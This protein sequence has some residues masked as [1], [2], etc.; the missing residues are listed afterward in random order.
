MYY[1]D[2]LLKLLNTGDREMTQ[3]GISENKAGGVI[4]IGGA[5]GA[6]KTTLAWHLI[7]EQGFTALVSV[8]YIREALRAPSLWPGGQVPVELQESSYVAADFLSQSR[9][10]VESIGRIATR[11]LKKGEMGV[12]EGVNLVPSQLSGMLAGSLKDRHLFIMLTVGVEVKHRERLSTRGA[13][14]IDHAPTITTIGRLLRED[15]EAT[16]Q[17][18]PDVNLIYID[19]SGPVADTTRVLRQQINRWKA[20]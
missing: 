6:G 15:A 16:R 8:D 9:Y 17:H 7:R 11:M 14:Y 20:S 5:T 10:L 1:P 4:F 2:A 18:T 3:A 13:R 12:I 19:A